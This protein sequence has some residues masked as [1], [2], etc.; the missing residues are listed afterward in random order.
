MNAG[1]SQWRVVFVAFASTW[2]IGF[3][4]QATSPFLVGTLIADLHLRA[5]LAGLIQ[6]TELMMVALTSLY[7]APRISTFSKRKLGVAG[8][9]LAGCMHA[10]SMVT[11]HVGALFV[12]RAIAGIGAGC[13]LSA[14]NALIASLREPERAYARVFIFAAAAFGGILLALGYI[15]QA[16]GVKGTYGFEAVWTFAMLPILWFLPADAPSQSG[17]T[18]GW[19]GI[20]LL[21]LVLILA[22][23]LMFEICDVGVWS[24]SERVAHSVDI[25]MGDSGW[26]LAAS[27]ALGVAGAY[28]ASTI[29]FRRGSVWP[30]VV[31]LLGF[32]LTCFEILTAHSQ[33]VYVVAIIVYQ[34]V[35]GFTL[36]YLYGTAGLMDPSGRII[37]A[38]SGTA[39][40]GAS[41][42]PFVVGMI[43]E[44]ANFASMGWL[45]LSCILIV[46]LMMLGIG[47]AQ[48]RSLRVASD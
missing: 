47:F 14:G 36:P 4:S 42:G 2:G 34:G 40:I 39:L 13:T 46:L 11:G 16:Y 7:L 3:L 31:G 8:A 44:H 26:A 9:V 32:G 30:L 10:A 29:G 41:V 28:V 38:C 48:S 19:S 6:S 21:P 24:F 33:T 43:S 1:G 35:Y 27:C 18:R 5:G 20:P 45:A 37:V 17:D 25:T 15:G 12:V 23:F 22:A